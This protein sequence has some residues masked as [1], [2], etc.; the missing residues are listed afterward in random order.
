MSINISDINYV[1]YASDDFRDILKLINSKETC[2][3][4]YG[5]L[6]K[7]SIH[8]DSDLGGEIGSN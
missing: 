1:P 3:E 8:H 2:H 6:E 7:S 4:A 5:E